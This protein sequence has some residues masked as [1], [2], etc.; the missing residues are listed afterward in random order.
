[1]SSRLYNFTL[2]EDNSKYRHSFS[3]TIVSTDKDI[4]KEQEESLEQIIKPY[5]KT[6]A[7][8]KIL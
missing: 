5:L 3:Q 8:E 1:M 2:K 7:I 6:L 4:S